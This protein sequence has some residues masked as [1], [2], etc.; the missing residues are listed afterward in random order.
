MAVSTIE[1][2]LAWYEAHPVE[3][4]P[5]EI[6]TCPVCKGRGTWPVPKP[7]PIVVEPWDDSSLRIDEAYSFPGRPDGSHPWDY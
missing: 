7:D 2:L 6:E 3:P 5:V 4:A 1:D